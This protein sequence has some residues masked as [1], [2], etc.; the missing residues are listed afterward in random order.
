MYLQLTTKCNMTCAHCCFS[1]NNKGDNMSRYTFATA[2]SL[3]ERI[4]GMVTL[5]GGEPTVH[6]EFFEY[7][8]RAIDY[9]DRGRLELAPLVVT[10]GKLV[11]KARKLLQ[12]VEEE[13]G[14]WVDL[15]LDDYHDPIRPEIEMA[16][17][18]YH[19]ARMRDRYGIRRNA[20]DRGAGIRTAKV[21]V[22]VGRAADKARGLPVDDTLSCCCEDMLVDPLGNVFS[23]GCKTHLLGNIFEDDSVFEGYDRE[24]AHEGGGLPAREHA[25]LY[26][27]IQKAA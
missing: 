13:R 15:S 25:R 20:G 3:A 8:D 14:V 2:L 9:Y 17:R 5:G 21:L 26:P 23:C 16:F 10:N 24:F 12:Y 18:R 27:E 4:S 1:A 11:S 19:E 22:P 6:P 7:L